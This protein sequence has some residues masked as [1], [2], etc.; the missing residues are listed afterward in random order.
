MA[1]HASG[2]CRVVHLKE[3]PTQVEQLRVGRYW[4]PM[5]ASDSSPRTS[6]P[7]IAV[8]H[9]VA[10]LG[11]I[12]PVTVLRTRSAKPNQYSYTSPA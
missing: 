5:S 8:G 2:G 4:R 11:S 12:R 10:G 3:A 6:A 1:L 7:R 9:L